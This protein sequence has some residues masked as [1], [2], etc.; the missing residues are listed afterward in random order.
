MGRQRD[1]NRTRER[2]LAAAT[3]E[4]AAKGLAGARTRAIAR[5]AGM[6]EQMIFHCFGS[7]EGLYRSVLDEEL[8]RIATL[9]ESRE[10][11]SFATHLATGFETLCDSDDQLR[12]WQWE[13][14]TG[15]RR[16]LIAAEERRIFLR[17]EAAQLRRAKVRGNLPEDVDAELMLIASIALRSIPLLLPQLVLLVTGL[18]S[19][20]PVF[21]RRWSRFL[22][23]LGDRISRS[24]T[25]P[26]VRAGHP[27]RLRSRPGEKPRRSNGISGKRHG[28]SG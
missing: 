24:S 2:I 22:R 18:Q 4:F 23:T 14:L 19:V 7:K 11:M 16:D 13:A 20:N 21:R 15:G 27:A 12:M 17:A 1:P 8:S 10:H 9:L 28:L 25:L 5:R 6:N 26:C 3:K